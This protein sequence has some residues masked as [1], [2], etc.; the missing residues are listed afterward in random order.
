MPGAD[1]DHDAVGEV[2][3]AIAREFRRRLQDEYVPRIGQCVERLGDRVWERP[4]PNCNSVGNLL[5][6]LAGNTR[7]WIHATFGEGADD[8]DRDAEFAAVRGAT[9]S[10]LVERLATVVDEACRIVDD[11]PATEWLR[12][13]T[14]Q[15][16]F[17][18]TGLSAVLHVLE[19]FSGHAGQIYAWTKQATGDDLKFYDL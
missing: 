16:Q 9:G 8:R 7:Q 18:E 11:L 1:S 17:E 3:T 15:Q 12:E 5:L 14:V 6:H 10:E 19:H 13:R 2:T 4:A